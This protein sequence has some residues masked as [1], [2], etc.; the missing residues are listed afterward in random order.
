[1]SDLRRFRP[2][3]VLVLLALFTILVWD[4]TFRPVDAKNTA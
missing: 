3:Y 4:V 2:W 1:M